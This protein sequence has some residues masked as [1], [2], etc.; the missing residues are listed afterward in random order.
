[1]VTDIRDGSTAKRCGEEEATM[2]PRTDAG[3]TPSQVVRTALKHDDSLVRLPDSTVV[4]G[5]VLTIMMPFY[6][7]VAAWR[8]FWLTA[9]LSPAIVS[10]Y[11]FVVVVSPVVTLAAS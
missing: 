4:A 10:D 11:L 1:M 7:C 6:G 5:K 2:I 8:V 3:R 9:R